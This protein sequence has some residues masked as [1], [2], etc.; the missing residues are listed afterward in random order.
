[1]QFGI[2]PVRSNVLCS[3]WLPSH[4]ELFKCIMCCTLA[5]SV[6]SFQ[7][8]PNHSVIQMNV[9]HSVDKVSDVNIHI[10]DYLIPSL[11]CNQCV[12]SLGKNQHRS[13][14]RFARQIPF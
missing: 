7:P 13:R 4:S 9:S 3:D 1:M 14:K 6:C 10:I 12:F 11:S 8:W 2:H 5:C